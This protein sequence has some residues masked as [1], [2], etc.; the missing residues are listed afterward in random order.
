MI[1]IFTCITCKKDKRECWISGE[2]TEER[3]ICEDCLNNEDDIIEIY[4]FICQ[5]CGGMYDCAVVIDGLCI[6]PNCEKDKYE[7]KK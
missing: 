6:C 1:T 4:P 7:G 5:D 2:R 3:L